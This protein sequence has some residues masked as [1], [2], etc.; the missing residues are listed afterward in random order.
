M[1]AINDGGPAFP[2]ST[3]NATDG[4]QDGASTRQFSGVGLRD[5]FAGKALQG[6]IAG[7]PSD[8]DWSKYA[9]DISMR[10]FR[11]ADAMLKAREQQP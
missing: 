11:M 4:H 8:F 10:V 1:N 7:M 6:E 9:D 5:Y 2:A 3:S